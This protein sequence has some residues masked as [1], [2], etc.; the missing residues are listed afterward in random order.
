MGCTSPWKFDSSQP[1]RRSDD[2]AW[3]Q[4][5]AVIVRESGPSSLSGTLNLWPRARPRPLRGRA[6]PCRSRRDRPSDRM[7]H[8]SGDRETHRRARDRG[9]RA[10]PLDP[11]PAGE[12]ERAPEG[13]SG[14]S[15][16]GRGTRSPKTGNRGATA[17]RRRRARVRRA[18]PGR[19]WRSHDRARVRDRA[20]SRRSSR[21]REGR[22]PS[23]GPRW[24][25]SEALNSTGPMLQGPAGISRKV[26]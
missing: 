1:H 19:R 6:R 24:A 20:G 5:D 8:C 2:G 25:T 23:V 21:P 14:P 16:G 17:R 11:A 3:R 15:H 13:S 9:G 4:P 10:Q 12:E 18:S 7:P 22:Y 26:T